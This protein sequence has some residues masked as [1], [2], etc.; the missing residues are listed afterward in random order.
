MKNRQIE[1]KVLDALA[2]TPV[3]LLVGGRQT[4][5]S[6]LAKKLAEGR[7][8]ARYLTLDD[9]AVLSAATSNPQ[10]FVDSLSEPVILDEV[11]RSPDLLL[12]IKASV[13]RKRVPG[14]F[15]LTGS[16]NVLLLPRIAD[17]LAGRMEVLTLWP[18]SQSEIEERSGSVIDT[19]FAKRIAVAGE[20]A[21]TAETLMLRMTTGG[22]PEAVQRSTPQRR[23]A[24]F[25][26]YITTIL[27]RDIRDIA[28]I[29]NLT[30]LP[31]V[32]S[33]L[34][35]RTGS[36]LNVA[37]L[38][39]S[40]AIPQSTLKRYLTLLETTFLIYR[41]PAWTTNRSKRLIK[42]P[43]IYLTDTGLATHLLGV[44]AGQLEANRTLSGH[45]MENFVLT[46]LLKHAGWS[47]TQPTIHHF[48]THGGQEVDFV[49]E[50]PDGSIVGVEVK[51]AAGVDASSFDALRTLAEEAGT[52]FVRGI[53]FYSGREVVT[54]AKNLQAVPMS[55]LWS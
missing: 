16:A 4:G 30:T 13:D 33:L 52:R 21:E 42:T 3:V 24:W 40:T 37:E 28:N 32:L 39:N 19:L 50:A 31:K 49:L 7:Y 34:A 10:A 14:K 9:A 35:T 18:F 20:R 12:A 36:L 38:S 15:L 47:E 45:L 48:R 23:G 25:G 2:D 44:N 17:S 27:Q 41:L 43:K 22:F 11:Q 29:E 55:F 46:E 26:S 6:T 1:T 51:S 54:F 5:K 53:V 8:T